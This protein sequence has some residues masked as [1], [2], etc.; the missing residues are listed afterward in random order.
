MVVFRLLKEL[1]A[2]AVYRLLG[3]PLG[4]RGDLIPG[5]SD[6]REGPVGQTEQGLRRLLLPPLNPGFRHRR[7]M[8]RKIS[9]PT[10]AMVSPIWMNGLTNSVNGTDVF[11][12]DVRMVPLLIFIGGSIACP[13]V[14]RRVVAHGFRPAPFQGDVAAPGFG[15]NCFEICR[16][17]ALQAA[18]GRVLQP[19]SPRRRIGIL[20]LKP[21]FAGRDTL[22]KR[23][24]LMHEPVLGPDMPGHGHAN[25]NPV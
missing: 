21:K 14:H 5:D 15:F 9:S 1:R 22:R 10:L 3:G 12:G 17:T 19:I 20:Q 8:D 13:G 11:E 7:R 16:E 2:D 18:H 23:D 4:D 6:V 25:P 24:P